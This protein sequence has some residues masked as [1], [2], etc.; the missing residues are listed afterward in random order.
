[1]LHILQILNPAYHADPNI[2]NPTYFLISHAPVRYAGVL[3]YPEWLYGQVPKFSAIER[4]NTSHLYT[5]PIISKILSVIL[6]RVF[7]A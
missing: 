5:F 4:C 6:V 1:M 3:D 7:F 2:V